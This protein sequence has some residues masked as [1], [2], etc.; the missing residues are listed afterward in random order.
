M[1]LELLGLLNKNENMNNINNTI[2]INKDVK[3]SSTE[4][5]ELLHEIIEKSQTPKI[6]KIFGEYLL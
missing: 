6:I 5:K 1:S 2:I 4:L 3:N